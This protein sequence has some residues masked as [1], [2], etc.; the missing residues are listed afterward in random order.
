M[1]AYSTFVSGVVL[2]SWS[3][4]IAW[5]R[6]R[7]SEPP[8]L[9]VVPHLAPPPRLHRDAGYLYTIGTHTLYDLYSL[10]SLNDAQV[11]LAWIHPTQLDSSLSSSSPAIDQLAF[12]I[13]SPSSNLVDLSLAPPVVLSL[14][15]P[16]DG[17]I[18]QLASDDLTRS[19]QLSSLTT[20]PAFAKFEIVA[21]PLRR[22]TRAVV[23]G[24][25]AD[26][27]RG[28]PRVPERDVERIQ[29]LLDDLTYEHVLGAL[30]S[31][32]SEKRIRHDVRVLSGED[33]SEIVHEERW[34]SRHS[35]SSGAI[36]A[37]DWLF[38]QM[39]SY[40]F[41][42]TRHSFLPDF[43]PMLECVYTRSGRGTEANETVVLGAHY[44]SR[45]SFGF[46][47]APGADDDASGTALVL[48][49]AREM[50]KNRLVFSRKLVLALFAGEEQGL[51]G[52]AWYAHELVHVRHEQVIWMLQ[53]DM[54]GYKVAAEPYQLALP[55]KIGLPEASW[56]VGNLSNVY[57]PE[58][59]VGNTGACC[60]DHQ[61]F[62]ANG[63]AS[64]WLFERN[65]PIA[66]PCYHDSCDKSSRPGYSFPQILMHVKVAF[67]TVWVV[68]KGRLE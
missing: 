65:G 60:S 23:D 25:D 54:V 36:S 19:R 67:S 15:D 5:A 31:E 22:T 52:S 63:V 48:A 58:L 59:V 16:R 42:C 38:A 50:W 34:V 17:F 8:H 21:I 33:Q 44:D 68:A 4:T 24:L 37:S 40:G 57:V 43:A 9:D 13:I 1:L 39:S 12:P 41:D 45:G 10:D 27:P 64:T 2:W 30:L 3:S 55:D 46:P 62:V 61:S 11:P 53:V 35:M 14:P 28:P 56:L 26:E 47:T 51:L 7:P 6:P 18:V 66:D 49:V 29:H 32:L 20:D